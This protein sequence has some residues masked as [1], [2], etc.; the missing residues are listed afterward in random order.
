MYEIAQQISFKC[1]IL[2]PKKI[3]FIISILI[4]YLSIIILWSNIFHNFYNFLIFY[5]LIF[6]GDF[7]NQI[8][9]IFFLVL[10]ILEDAMKN[11]PYSFAV[12]GSNVTG[13]EKRNPVT[14]RIN[15]INTSAVKFNLLDIVCT[16]SRSSATEE[17]FF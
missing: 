2:F 8:Y 17:G 10:P 16:S 12:D 3:S 1:V 11:Q 4:L 15:G 6:C 14:E 9:F 7:L 5:L 13:L